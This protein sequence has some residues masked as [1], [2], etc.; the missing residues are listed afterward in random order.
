LIPFKTSPFN[1]QDPNYLVMQAHA[2]DGKAGA[3]MAV[4]NISRDR[5]GTQG[6]LM[7]T[8]SF[9]EGS[10]YIGVL[11]EMIHFGETITPEVV[12]RHLNKRNGTM[13]FSDE[14]KPSLRGE[15]LCD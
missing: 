2:F 15:I 14:L 13:R 7:V 10:G 3:S 8:A 12:F 4:Q 9:K 6:K 5:P 11:T 1:P